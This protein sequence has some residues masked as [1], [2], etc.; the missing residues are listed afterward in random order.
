MQKTKIIAEIGNNHNGNFKKALVGI[1]NSKKAGADFVKFQFITP[2]KLVTKKLKSL[3]KSKEKYQIQRLKKI[4][5]PLDQIKKLFLFSTTVR[6]T[7]LH[8][9]II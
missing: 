4:C 1:I 6:K 7:F 5:L 2:E 9:T 3:I 8:V